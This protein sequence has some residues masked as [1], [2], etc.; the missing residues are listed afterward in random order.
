VLVGESGLTHPH[1]HR[2]VKV[3]EPAGALAL[4][5]LHGNS[6]FAEPLFAA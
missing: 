5:A 2:F 3:L 1:H 4:R 6:T